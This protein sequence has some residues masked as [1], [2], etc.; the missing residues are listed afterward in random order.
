MKTFTL[1]IP[2]NHINQSI[3]DALGLD[4]SHTHGS[5]LIA[6]PTITFAVHLLRKRGFP[7]FPSDGHGLV[8]AKIGPEN[9]LA[10]AGLLDNQIVLVGGFFQGRA[11][12]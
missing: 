5:W 2:H 10:A 4:V 3:R 6:A 12:R 1:S 9:V 7:D 8:K 11:T